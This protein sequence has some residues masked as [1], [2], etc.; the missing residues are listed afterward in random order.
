M[1]MAAAVTFVLGQGV[2]REHCIAHGFSLGGA[3]AAGAAVF[4]DL[5]GLTLDHSFTSIGEV[6]AGLAPGS[7]KQISAQVKAANEAGSGIKFVASIL[8]ILP[9]W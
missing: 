7:A 8:S 9:E 2:P 6:A 5:G 3:L 1:D 4:Y